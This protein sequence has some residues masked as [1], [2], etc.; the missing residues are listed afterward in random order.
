MTSKPSPDGPA[1][2]V[3]PGRETRKPRTLWVRSRLLILMAA[4]WGILFWYALSSDPLISARDGLIITWNTK[5]WL[6]VLFCAELVRQA[7]YI[8]SEHWGAWDHFWGDVFFGGLHRRT[9]RLSNWSR[10]RARRIFTVVL[11]IVAAAIIAGAAY[12]VNPVEGLFEVPGKFF[13]ALPGIVQ[14]LFYLMFGVSQFV[15]IFWYM[16]R[17][18]VDVYY[19]DDVKTRFSDVWGQD[20]VLERVKECMVFLEDPESIEARGGYVPGGI[21]LWGPPGTGKTLLAEAVAGETG[22]PFVFVDPGAFVNMFLGVGILK[23]KR[24]FRKLRQLAIRYGGV[25]VFFDEADSLGSRGALS[26]GGIF[27]PA[28]YGA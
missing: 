16:S 12:Q 4:V 21:L 15:L 1:L 18:G 5:W 9:G 17:G 14:V 26:G 2:E 11:L 20:A 3:V 19:P 22:K 10:Y 28:A 7:H 8:I 25:I 6:T 24:L 23:V 27:G 13:S